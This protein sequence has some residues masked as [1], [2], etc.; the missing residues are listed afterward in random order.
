LIEDKERIFHAFVK[1][2]IWVEIDEE[3]SYNA[4]MVTEV[5]LD[6]SEENMDKKRNE[7]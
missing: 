7:S 4:S 5:V 1:Y 3:T 6:A 2:R